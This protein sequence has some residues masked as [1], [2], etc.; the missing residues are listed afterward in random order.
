MHNADTLFQHTLQKLACIKEA[1]KAQKSGQ[2]D[3]ANGCTARRTRTRGAA[4]QAA[5]IP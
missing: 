5:T 3:T 2:A 1:A 4:A